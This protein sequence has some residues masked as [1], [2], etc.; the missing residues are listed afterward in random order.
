MV[1]ESLIVLKWESEYNLKNSNYVQKYQLT[2]IKVL[3][4]LKVEDVLIET[5]TFTE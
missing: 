2:L 1:K 3:T 5:P 4:C